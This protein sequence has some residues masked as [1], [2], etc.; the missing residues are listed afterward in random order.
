MDCGGRMCSYVCK[1]GDLI[2][3]IY[4][5][6]YVTKWLKISCMGLKEYINGFSFYHILCRYTHIVLYCRIDVEIFK[7]I[8]KMGVKKKV[9]YSSHINVHIYF[10][11]ICYIWALLSFTFLLSILLW[12]SRISIPSHRIQSNTYT[13]S[14]IA[15]TISIILTICV[16]THVYEIKRIKYKYMWCRCDAR[17]MGDGDGDGDMVR[18]LD[19]ADVSWLGFWLEDM[20]GMGSAL[21]GGVSI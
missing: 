14:Y 20:I 10:V 5:K 4:I 6:T 15:A 3:I 9:A 21:V 1:E 11:L 17:M 13:R 19:D 18:L 8:Y 2:I 12:L 7:H 16:Y